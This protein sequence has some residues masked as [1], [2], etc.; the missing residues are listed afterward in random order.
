MPKHGKK[1]PFAFG[2]ISTLMQ[3]VLASM[4]LRQKF[5]GRLTC[6]VSHGTLPLFVIADT[7]SFHVFAVNSDGTITFISTYAEPYIRNG[8]I[9]NITFVPTMPCNGSIQI[10]ITGYTNGHITAVMLDTSGN[11]TKIA[12][13][14]GNCV[15][16]PASLWVHNGEIWCSCLDG[17]LR[18]YR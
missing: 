18:R 6:C 10:I 13:I 15:N 1:E 11:L 5:L 7:G 17:F 8:S 4:C 14:S 3:M 12:H 9:S 2:F 16:K